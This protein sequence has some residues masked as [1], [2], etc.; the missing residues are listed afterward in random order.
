MFGYTP[1]HKHVK[2]LVKDIL[3]LCYAIPKLQ[4]VTMCSSNDIWATVTIQM[5]DSPYDDRVL[6][7]TPTTKAVGTACPFSNVAIKTSAGSAASTITSRSLPLFVMTCPE[8][9]EGRHRN[10]R[11][12]SV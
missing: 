10:R 9:A 2:Q 5:N 8:L 11:A 4:S 3:L 1:E 7:T 6:T 12:E